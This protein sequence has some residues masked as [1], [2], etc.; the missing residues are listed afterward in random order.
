MN[1]TYAKFFGDRPP[2]RS[3]IEVARLP[4]DVQ[5]EI[6]AIAFDASRK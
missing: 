5:V 4:R 2:A 1:E 6:E 3:T